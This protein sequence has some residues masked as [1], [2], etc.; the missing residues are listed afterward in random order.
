MSWS[1]YKCTRS[2]SQL[3]FQY[4]TYVTF[5]A[6]VACLSRLPY[7]QRIALGGVWFQYIVSPISGSKARIS[8][9]IEHVWP[10]LDLEDKQ[11]IFG[12]VPNNIGRTF[13]EL[14]FPDDFLRIIEACEITGE[15]YNAFKDAQLTGQPVI[16]V[17]GH[18]GNYDSIRGRLVLE[19]HNIGSLY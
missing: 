10:N 5:G 6:I 4:L 3:V 7:T 9:N 14:F 1:F 13:T 19:G 18:F 16:L 11:K 8:E 2:H 12:G 15:G 17:A